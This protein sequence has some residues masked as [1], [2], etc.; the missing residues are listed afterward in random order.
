MA[1]YRLAEFEENR[2]HDSYGYLVYWDSET[3]SVDRVM[4]WTTASAGGLDT[5]EYLEPTLEVVEEA[6]EWFS[7]RIHRQNMRQQ[8]RAHY[9]PTEKWHVTL[10]STVVFKKSHN[11]RKSKIKIAEGTEA[12]LVGVS[13]DNF[14]TRSYSRFTYYNVSVMIDNKIVSVPMEKV[15]TAG[16]P[17]LSVKEEKVRAKNSAYNCQFRSMWY[18]GWDCRNWALKVLEEKNKEI[19]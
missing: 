2:Y 5:S 7:K 15:R 4:H 10:G 12:K 3:K 8:I 11:S 17:N 6:V 1:K 19:A 18:G 9:S 16:R 13:V 14:K